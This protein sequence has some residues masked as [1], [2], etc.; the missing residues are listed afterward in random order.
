MDKIQPPPNLSLTGNVHENWKRFKQRFELYLVAIGAAKKSDEQKIALFLT[1]AGPDTIEVYNTLEFNDDDKD[2]YDV[3]IKKIE[4]YCTPRKNETYERYVFRS[5]MQT[6]DESFEQFVT[7]LKI[8]SQSCG[9]GDL[10]ESLVRDQ[11][12]IGL[13]DKKLKERLLRE[14]DLTLKKAIEICQAAETAKT[15]MKTLQNEDK[16]ATVV[17]AVKRGMEQRSRNSKPSSMSANKP[18]DPQSNRQ[19]CQ[20]CGRI[21]EWRNCPAYGKVCH[22]CHKKNHFEKMCRQKDVNTLEHA[23]QSDT[24]SE[25][26]EFFMGAISTQ[27]TKGKDWMSNVKVNG[28][29]I[30]FKLDTGAQ[31]NVIPLAEYNKLINKPKIEHKKVVLKTYTGG[32]IPVTGVCNLEIECNNQKSTEMFVIVPSNC[33]PILGLDCCERFNFVNRVHTVHTSDKKLNDGLASEF[34]D[35]FEGIGCL[36]VTYKIKLKDDAVPVIHAARKVPIALKDRLKT[37]LNRLTDLGIVKKVEEPTE[38]VSSLVIIEKD[39]GDLRL[40]LDP[41]ELNDN[42]K[43]EHYHI[44]TRSEVTHDIA[45]AEY[46]SKLDASSGFWQIPLDEDSAKLCTFNTPYGRYCF[47]RLPFGISSA[48]EVFHRTVE[49]LFEGIDGVKSVHDDIIVWGRNLSDHDEHLRAALTKAREVGLKLN[50][51]KCRFRAKEITFLGDKITSNGVLPDPKKVEAINNMPQPTCKIELQRYLGMVNYLGKFVPNLSSKT[52]ALRSLLE[53]KSEWQWQPEHEE[54]WKQLNDFLTTEPVLKYFDSARRT[55]IS[56][57]ASKKGL[58]AVLLQEHDGVW[59]PVAY[60]SR[61]LTTAEQRYAT[62]EKETLGTVFACDKFHEF[63]YGLPDVI[64]ETDH[65]PLITIVK[66]SLCDTPPRIQR[67]MLKLQKYNL[68]FEHTPG[69]YLVVPDTLSRAFLQKPSDHTSERE[70]EIH[71]NLVKASLPVTENKWSEI[72]TATSTDTELRS[73]LKNIENGWGNGPY[74]KPYYHFRHELTVIEGV[75]LKN[76]RVVVPTALRPD[77]LDRIHEGHMGIEKCRRRGRSTL[78]WPNMN[79]DIENKVSSCAVCQKYRYQQQKEP[80]LSHEVPD[81]PWMKVGADI[82]S[83]DGKDYLLVTD[84]MSC[85]PE[86]ALLS[87]KSTSRN[88]IVHLK[89]IFARHGIPKTMVTDN[90]SQFASEEFKTFTITY[91][92]EH[93]YSSPYH[94]QSN[95]QAEKGV[96]IVKNVL[97]KSLE[98]KEDPYLALL[99]YRSTPLDCGKS[100]AELCMNRKLRTTLPNVDDHNVNKDPRATKE[101]AKQKEHYDKGAKPLREL[102]A[103]ETVRIRGDNCWSKKAVVVEK[104]SPRAYKVKTEDGVVYNRNRRHLLPTKEHF[105]ETPDETVEKLSTDKSNELESLNN[106]NNTLPDVDN[107]NLRRSQRQR[108]R[109]ER[110]IESM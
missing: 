15:Q 27:Q 44:P 47:L 46:F 63:I 51:K 95:G 17:G 91:G 78:Y 12:V 57:D 94:A 66:K 29:E 72:A 100:P 48:P 28:Q 108:N 45:G 56:S 53:E 24:D 87:G 96:G 2:K 25:D 61:V 50:L 1:I 92:I 81:K 60:A 37:E 26:L 68:N 22:K 20:N 65:K 75:I 83:L 6:S 107:T 52:V 97:K 10:T 8:K 18:Q 85:Y 84:Y 36:P 86:F 67:L 82:Y 43:R 40:C 9:F 21:H 88:V 34:K 5:R 39:N 31:T 14:S 90:G 13:V 64:A 54:E 103:N 38:W 32:Q 16:D 93:K 77:M 101:R 74:P 33:Q 42:I 41:K 89:S 102:S 59:K 35:V 80:L 99:A 19:C 70:V 106:T 3:V 62:I 11:I 23:S 79:S 104:M 71:V 105:Q 4:E 98:C 7:D 73:V 109:P 55:K 76:N 110:L 69:K 58:G 49:Q 30:L